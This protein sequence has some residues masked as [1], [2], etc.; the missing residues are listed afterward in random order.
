MI[1]DGRFGVV[2]RTAAFSQNLAKA[3]LQSPE[4]SPDLVRPR[5]DLSIELLDPL[6]ADLVDDAAKLFDLRAEPFELFLGDA[7]M[8]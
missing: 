1:A 6:R 8:L 7:V 5:L 3:D 4:R 2:C